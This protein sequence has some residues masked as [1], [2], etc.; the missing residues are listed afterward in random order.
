[1]L[2]HL[3]NIKNGVVIR[4]IVEA[5]DG[6]GATSTTTTLTT[7]TRANIWSVGSGDTTISD[8]ITKNST[9]VL[10]LMYGEY[11]FTDSDRE[12]TYGGNTYEITGHA[13]NVA[14]R[15]ELLLVGLKWLS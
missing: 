7:L 10:A 8:K 2:R 6:Y 9:H 3:L 4:K 12:C 13:D 14:E 1:M 11:T 15:N 5:S